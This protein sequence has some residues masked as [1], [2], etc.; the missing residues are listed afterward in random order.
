[1]RTNYIMLVC[2]LTIRNTNIGTIISNN[3]LFLSSYLE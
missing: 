1:M 3:A 2:Q